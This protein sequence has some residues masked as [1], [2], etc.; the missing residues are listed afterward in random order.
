MLQSMHFDKQFGFR[1][2]LIGSNT[3]EAFE[4]VLVAFAFVF[5][6]LLQSMGFLLSAQS[7]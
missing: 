5:E 6:L 2:I 4:E 7:G 1:L 3:D